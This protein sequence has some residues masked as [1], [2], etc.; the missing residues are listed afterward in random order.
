MS[1]SLAATSSSTAFT[2]LSV[3]F[4]ISVSASFWVSWHGA[5]DDFAV[6]LRSESE[7]GVDDG[8]LDLRN[9]VF[10]PRLDRQGLGVRGRD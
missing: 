9:H 6:V 2:F 7:V 10:L 3:I 4:W 5:A 8:F 1:F